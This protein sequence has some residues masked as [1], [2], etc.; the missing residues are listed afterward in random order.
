MSNWDVAN[1]EAILGN[2]FTSMLKVKESVE[3]EFEVVQKAQGATFLE[4]QQTFSWHTTFRE[5]GAYFGTQKTFLGW[6]KL[7]LGYKRLFFRETNGNIL[8][9]I[10][11]HHKHLK[12][13]KY[14][15]IEKQ[16]YKKK[17]KGKRKKNKQ[18]TNV[19]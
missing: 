14:F 18:K 1:N 11:K 7:F 4:V 3:P 6:T 2:I 9:K 19:F 17:K 12:N 10:E 13:T 16:I 15:I 5:G 8:T